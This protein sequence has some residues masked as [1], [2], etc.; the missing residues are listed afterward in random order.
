M[1]KLQV[2]L[3]ARALRYLSA[4]EH[5]RQELARKLARYAQESDDVEALLDTL[6][7]AKFLSEARFS[8]SLVNRRAARFGNSRILSELKSHNI[9]PDTLTEIKA[10]LALDENARA[11]E[12]WLRKFGTVASDASGRAKQMR[13]L[14]QRG[15]S[16][17]AILAAMRAKDE[18]EY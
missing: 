13:F 6:E 1:A 2:S 17:R 15:F 14:L 7:A 5:S 4:R 12:V 3:K 18:D 11:R 10:G 9:D 8:E 16:H